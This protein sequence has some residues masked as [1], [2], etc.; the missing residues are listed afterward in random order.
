MNYIFDSDYL[1]SEIVKFMN[2]GDLFLY[3]QITKYTYFHITKDMVSNRINECIKNELQYRLQDKYVNFIG[4]VET[5]QMLIHG[6]FI[7]EIIWYGY[8]DVGMDIKLKE[9]HMGDFDDNIF[10]DVK[11]LGEDIDVIQKFVDLK[12]F[13]CYEYQK[14]VSIK[15]YN[16]DIEI[17]TPE[18][19]GDNYSTIFQNNVIIKDGQIIVHIKDYYSVMNKIQPISLNTKLEDDFDLKNEKSLYDKYNIKVKLE[20]LTTYSE[21]PLIIY[22]DY[23]FTLF[24]NTYPISGNRMRCHQI[25]IMDSNEIDKLWID[26][27]IEPF[28]TNFKH[29]ECVEDHQ[30]EL[31]CYKNCPLTI[32][33]IEHFH[34]C[35][36]AKL[37]EQKKI[38]KV[39]IIKDNESCSHS[40]YSYDIDKYCF[41]PFP[42]NKCH[43]DIEY[44]KHIF[45]NHFDEGDFKI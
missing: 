37:G 21:V 3:R 2:P 12:Q 15:K 22:N 44:Y 36:F 11:N 13:F 35:L 33:N 30:P 26:I 20:H 41:Y 1:T 25:I 23:N 43:R 31:G 42:P 39:I 5:R 18:V 32:F 4:I 29:Y 9:E 45:N 10:V 8:S 19:E 28:I 27:K 7:N 24:G 40:K 34:S 6:P 17:Y 16:I 14:Y 38:V